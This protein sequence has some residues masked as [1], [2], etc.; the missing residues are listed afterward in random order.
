MSDAQQLGGGG[1]VGG[2]LSRLGPQRASAA[3]RAA[4]PARRLASRLDLDILPAPPC[5]ATGAPTGWGGSTRS[6]RDAG[7]WAQPHRPGHTRVHA[8]PSSYHQPHTA[9]LAAF[10]FCG[11]FPL[12][13]SQVSVKRDERSTCLRRAGGRR[14][15]V[16]G[17]PDRASQ[18][19]TRCQLLWLA[20]PL[21]AR[22]L[23]VSSITSCT[24][25]SSC[26]Q[27]SP[28]RQT[29]LCQRGP[30]R[31]RS[32]PNVG[33]HAASSRPG[34]AEGW[35]RGPAL[36]SNYGSSQLLLQRARRGPAARPGGACSVSTMPVQRAPGRRPAAP[37]AAR[38]PPPPAPAPGAGAS[39]R[40][41]QPACPP[42]CRPAGA[43]PT[44]WTTGA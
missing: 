12:Q 1:R 27:A 13:V 18:R 4:G 33:T 32:A 21:A 23:R 30:S 16:G 5:S 29:Q 19:S 42:L 25:C 43:P 38:V 22:T 20:S 3:A 35:K 10:C 24:G 44:A 6:C 36:Q 40:L 7:R 17:A 26:R 41:C 9:V 11:S 15:V 28:D 2:V 37:L 39:L 14:A 34:A 31:S 8:A